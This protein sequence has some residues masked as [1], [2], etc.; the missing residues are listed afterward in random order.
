M[1]RRDFIMTAVASVPLL[2]IRG[3]HPG[4]TACED[5]QALYE[6]VL[7]IDALANPGSFNIPWPPQG[8]LL[9]EQIDNIRAS[10][11]TAVDVTVS[12][13]GFK[14]TVQQIARW[15]GELDKYPD[16]LSSVKH[17]EDLNRAKTEG[18]LGLILGFQHTEMLGRELSLLD[19]FHQLGVRI[20]QLTYNKRNYIGD[21]CLEPRDGGLS[22]FGRQ[23]VERLNA[24]GIAIDVSHCGPQTTNDAISQ[25]NAPILITHSGCKSVYDNPRNKDD[26]T[27]RAMADRGGVIGIY[28]MPFLG[29]DGSPYATKEMFYRHLDHALRVCGEAHVGIGSDLS[30]TPVEESPEYLKTWEEGNEIR[31]RLGIQAPDEAGRFPY[32]PDLN[33][34]RRLESIA[35]EMDRRGYSCTV[36]EQVLGANFKRAMGEI[37]GR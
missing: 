24:L 19:T 29:N 23:A 11:I 34:P 4:L 20:V 12:H 21:G 28:L 31:A 36:I 17:I 3:N 18:K 7:V 8:P 32:L 6:R 25:S 22:N 26:A 37:W 33:T 13:T 1:D 15:Q 27:L 10:G 16:L 9:P 2:G 5:V 35:E 30:I 14:Q